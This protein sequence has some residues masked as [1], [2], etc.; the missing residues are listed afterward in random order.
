MGVMFLLGVIPVAWIWLRPNPESMGLLPDGDAPDVDENDLTGKG[1]LALLKKLIGRKLNL[2]SA[3]K[4]R[5]AVAFSGASAWPI[6]S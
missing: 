2:A 3:S 5:A 6:Y 4:R 1:H